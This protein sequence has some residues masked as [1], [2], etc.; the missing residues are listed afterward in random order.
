MYAKVLALHFLNA[1][2][3]FVIALNA[4]LFQFKGD[5][6]IALSLK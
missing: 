5:E 1:H 6:L 2:S 4:L 3:R